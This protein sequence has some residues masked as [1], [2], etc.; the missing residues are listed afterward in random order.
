MGC[1]VHQEG[2]G[3]RSGIVRIVNRSDR[4]KTSRIRWL[5]GQSVIRDH[6]I[7]PGGNGDRIHLQNVRIV[8]LNQVGERHR[9]HL[10]PDRE[11]SRGKSIETIVGG[12]QASEA[13]CDGIRAGSTGGSSRGG[14]ASRATN[15]TRALP[16][17]K[18]GQAGGKGGIHRSIRSVGVLGNNRQAFL[19]NGETL[20]HWGGSEPTTVPR[21][22]RP[23]RDGAYTRQGHRTSTQC[24]RSAHHRIAHRQARACRGIQRKRSI[25]IHLVAQSPKRDR[26][27]RG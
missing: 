10:F 3:H 22:A 19:G 16:T 6:H 27:H 21:L 26:L 13:R 15:H 7:Q 4:R 24:C 20:I 5:V 17:G 25:P 11:R 1:L 8:G 14:K 2:V 23:N 12:T 9:S 18:T